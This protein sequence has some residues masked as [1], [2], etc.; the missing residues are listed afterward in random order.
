MI[1]KPIG[2][3]VKQGYYTL[4]LILASKDKRYGGEINEILKL[5]E[6]ITEDKLEDLFDMVIK[7]TDAI[8]Q[9]RILSK[10][11]IQKKATS[12]FDVLSGK[13]RCCS[14]IAINA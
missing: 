7:K 5:H 3:D 13:K 1:G 9:T 2:N 14:S 10:R 12:Q 11:Y 8:A 6:D 4:P